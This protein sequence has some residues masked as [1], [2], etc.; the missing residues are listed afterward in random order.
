M[1]ASETLDMSRGELTAD[2]EI[3]EAILRLC[4][5]K[6]Q[7][8]RDLSGRPFWFSSPR[9]KTG[10]HW[11][12]FFSPDGSCRLFDFKDED[13]AFVVGRPCSACMTGWGR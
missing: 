10:P 1:A 6:Y 12:I 8:G 9:S 3:V 2:I 5:V 13:S 7:E 11:H 4:G